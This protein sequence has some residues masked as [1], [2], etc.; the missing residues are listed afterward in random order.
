[1]PIL[2][3]VLSIL[4]LLAAAGPVLADQIPPSFPACPAPG[5]TL[6]ASYPTGTHGIPGDTGTYTGSDSVYTINDSQAVQCFCPT[7]GNSGIQT[8]WWQ[9][10]ELSQG[11]INYFK[12][13]GWVFI[14]DGSAWGLDSAFYF[15]YNTSFSCGGGGGGGFSPSG[16]GSA[17]V[18][19]AAKPPSPVLTSV[20]RHGSTATLTWTKIDSATHYAIW[21]GTAPGQFDYGVPN[22]GKVT[23]FTVGSLD[24][25]KQYYW[26]VRS[27][28]DC[29]PSDPA[30]GIGGGDVLGAFA[31]TGNAT[32][33]VII[34][35]LG[36]IFFGLSLLA[37][38]RNRPQA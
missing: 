37:R 6:K 8:N 10:D 33:I 3:L 23:S 2:S 32:T 11:D 1:M 28:N 27:V 31:P 30:S 18:C 14:P 35:S 24:P 22:T 34:A 36:L 20:T 21:Y 12:S 15:A 26:E 38:D 13:L 4:L 16:P 5:G 17:P 19:S 29:M 9:V 25:G 7:T